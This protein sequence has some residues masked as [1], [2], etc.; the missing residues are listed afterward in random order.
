[1][2]VLEQG[3]EFFCYL[4]DGATWTKRAVKIGDSSDKYIE[5]QDGLNEGDQVIL[6]P[7]A[8]IPD[9]QRIVE[10]PVNPSGK[11]RSELASDPV[12]ASEKSDKT[13]P[14]STSEGDAASAGSAQLASDVSPAAPNTAEKRKSP[15]RNEQKSKKPT[16]GSRS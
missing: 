14:K 16:V 12:R 13:A 6:N 11:V 4:S 15:A 3:D 7:R 2:G 9:A 8:T 10:R 5:I 1:L